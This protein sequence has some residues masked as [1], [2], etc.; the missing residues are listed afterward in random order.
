MREKGKVVEMAD[1][2]AKI[3]LEPSEACK[4]C[5]SCNFCRPSGSTRII[6]VENRIGAQV[7]DEVFIE[8]SHKKS[9]IAILLLFGVPV[10]LG[11][12]G[13]VVGAH[14]SEGYSVF[15][16]ISG[17]VLGLILAKVINNI[18][19]RTHKLSP[20]IVEVTRSKKP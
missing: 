13:L 20:H 10:L 6:E 11:L 17:F 2:I 5:P 19:R 14:Y 7:G 15:L 9:L 8:I 1:F 4:D 3:S 18:F 12:I 16:G